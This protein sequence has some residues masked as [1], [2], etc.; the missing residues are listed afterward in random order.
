MPMLEQLKAYYKDA[1][2]TC[3]T[4]S[5]HD[6][7]EWFYTNNGEQVGILKEIL[8]EKEKKLLSIFLKPISQEHR[9]MNKHE[10]A[11]YDFLIYGNTEQIRLISNHSRYYRFIHFKI[12]QTTV[13]KEDFCEAIKELFPSEIMIVWENDNEGVVIEKKGEGDEIDSFAEIIDTLSSDLYIALSLFVGQKYPYSEKLN[14]Y[15][16]FEKQCFHLAK[17]SISNQNI[18]TIEDVFPLLLIKN[19]VQKQELQYAIHFID[20]IKEDKELLTTMKVFFECNL[21]VSLAAKKL[22]IHRNS[23]QYRIDKFIE[24]TG[25]D[26]KH[27]KGASAAYLAMLAHE[28]LNKEH[29]HNA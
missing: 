4:P 11:W 22:Y 26:I 21:N 5:N 24:R 2:I 19:S 3:K 9:M 28:Y 8:T 6:D 7:Y 15:Y 20:A 29:R 12:K 13:D 10:L 1:L 14:D 25:I 23:L 16:A 18:Y 17:T 27:F